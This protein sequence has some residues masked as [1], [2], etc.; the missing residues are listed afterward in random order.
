MLITIHGGH[1]YPGKG[2]TGTVGY[3]NESLQDRI[4]KDKVKALLEL[5]GNAVSDITV[6][7]GSQKE[8][9]S[10]LTSRANAANA[11]LNVSIHFNASNGK[12]YGVEVLV[13]EGDNRPVDVASRVVDRIVDLGFRN[14]GVKTSGSLYILNKMINPTIL[15]ECCFADNY[16]DFKRYDADQ[17]ARAIAEG[18]VGHPIV[19]VKETR[20][21]TLDLVDFGVYS[22]KNVSPVFRLYN[23]SSGEH[24]FTTSIVESDILIDAG[25]SFEGVGWLEPTGA[26]NVPVHRLYNPNDGDH[27]FTICQNEAVYLQGLGWSY[28]GI[29]FYSDHRE[30]VPVYRLY[31]PDKKGAGSHF[32][33]A[34]AEEKDNLIS[35]GWVPEGI[36][37]FG[38]AL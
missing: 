1:G 35:L 13:K 12:G 2:A 19:D 18:I 32:Y 4:V 27:F 36:G 34:N 26:G 3:I 15:I 10:K 16:D 20:Q 6:D 28:E 7:E 29:A 22:G 23:G 30:G 38:G 8:I 21:H 37:W 25:W 33:T 11:D 24:F 14:R 9:L 17:M 31:N 5:D